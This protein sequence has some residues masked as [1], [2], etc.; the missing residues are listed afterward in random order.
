MIDV[1]RNDT[2]AGL[3]ISSV[4]AYSAKGARVTI[5]NGQLRYVPRSG[6][7]GSDTFWYVISDNQNRTNAVVVTVNVSN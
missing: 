2:G 4:N 1:L 6:Y 5:E 3:R 7:S